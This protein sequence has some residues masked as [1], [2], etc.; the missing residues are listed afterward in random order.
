ML[1]NYGKYHRHHS[2]ATYDGNHHSLATL[3]PNDGDDGDDGDDGHR[4]ATM[5][6]DYPG[7]YATPIYNL[8]LPSSL[9]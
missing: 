2:L 3:M 6:S 7:P 5:L 9:F 4:L 1:P 8:H